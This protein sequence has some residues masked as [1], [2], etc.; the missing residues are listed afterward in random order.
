MRKRRFRVLAS[1]TVEKSAARLARYRSA[2]SAPERERKRAGRRITGGKERV[3]SGRTTPF[4]GRP[5]SDTCRKLDEERSGGGGQKRLECSGKRP[6][7]ARFLREV[8]DEERD[9]IARTERGDFSKVWTL[10]TD[11]TF[12]RRDEKGDQVNA[13]LAR[14]P[15]SINGYDP[16]TDRWTTTADDGTILITFVLSDDVLQVKVLRMQ[17]LRAALHVRRT[18]ALW[19]TRRVVLTSTRPRPVFLTCEKR[20]PAAPGVVSHRERIRRTGRF[21]PHR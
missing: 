20:P 21:S 2:A 16:R 8:L 1:G 6:R 10:D 11:S 13:R 15:K 7:D 19:A 5:A 14:E 9:A 17:D 4:E 12:W 3:D 18:R